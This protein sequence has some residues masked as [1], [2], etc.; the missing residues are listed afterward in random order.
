MWKDETTLLDIDDPLSRESTGCS[1]PRGRQ[2]MSIGHIDSELA[3]RVPLDRIGEAC[4]RFGVSQLWVHGPILERD[5]G[6]TGEVEFLVEFLNNDAGPWGSK[7]DLLEN[8]LSGVLHRKVRVSSRGG[9]QDSTPSP[10]REQILNSAR[11]I[12]EL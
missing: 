12:Y 5:P 9:I 4:R 2:T 6:P 7:L 10:W 8:D 1:S 3:T 11:L